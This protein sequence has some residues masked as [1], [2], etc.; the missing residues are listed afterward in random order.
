ME[1]TKQFIKQVELSTR[2]VVT[3]RDPQG[4]LCTLNEMFKNATWL[5]ENVEHLL[6]EL[7]RLRQDNLECHRVMRQIL[8]ELP[9]RHDWLKPDL[10]K[11]LASL[12]G[13]GITQYAAE[14]SPV[15]AGSKLNENESIHPD[16]VNH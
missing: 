1:N 11:R 5:G 7:D 14:A 10:E 2:V 8:F 12:V 16:R 15:S 9:R 13:R 6:K 3:G 4:T